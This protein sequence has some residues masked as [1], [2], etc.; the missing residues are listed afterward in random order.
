MT[1][2]GAVPQQ[3]EVPLVDESRLVG[4]EPAFGPW[5]L[6]TAPGLLGPVGYPGAV[7]RGPDS[8]PFILAID[9]RGASGKS[10][11]ARTIV[12]ATPQSA[13]V[14]TDDLAWNEPFF[15]WAH[16]LREV[17]ET[18]RAGNSLKLRPPAWERAGR[19]GAVALPAGLSL[20]VVEGV[21][22][23]QCDVVELV[24]AVIWVQSDFSVAE[25]RGIERDIAEGVNGT[26]DETI[27]FWHEWMSHELTFLE[28][29]RP[30]ER[31]DAIVL[32]TP[33]SG[34]V[35]PGKLAVDLSPGARRSAGNRDSGT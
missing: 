21:G 2:S 7:G 16:L 6:A 8:R 18:L 17:L 29:E 28:R 3:P 33:A 23:S 11:L 25:R 32:G 26:R 20:V 19:P 15:Q 4:G 31:A 22:A 14:H 30:W 12:D 13:L 27:T 1:S 10:T 5:Q 34:V 9:G 35:P 24:D